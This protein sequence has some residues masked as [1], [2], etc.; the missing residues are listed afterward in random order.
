MMKLT[1]S[2]NI[3]G[4]A[5]EAVRNKPV[6]EQGFQFADTLGK[7]SQNDTTSARSFYV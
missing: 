2:I 4:K 7:A 1:H 6:L 3:S 5:F